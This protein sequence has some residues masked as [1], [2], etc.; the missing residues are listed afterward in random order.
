MANAHRAAGGHHRIGVEGT[1]VAPIT[2]RHGQTQ[3]SLASYRPINTWT[4]KL[5]DFVMWHGWLWSRWYGVINGIQQDKIVSIVREGLPCLLFT[6]DES[7]YEK[8]TIHIPIIKIR[9]CQNGEYHVLQDGV[10]YI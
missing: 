7:E 9:G 2:R 8:K 4:P 6:L 3:I 10:W 1:P 5:T